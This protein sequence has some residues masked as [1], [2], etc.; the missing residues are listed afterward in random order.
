MCYLPAPSPRGSV[1]PPSQPCC[2]PGHDCVN[3]QM[4]IARHNGQPGP[5]LIVSDGV[6]VQPPSPL[7]PSRPPHTRR[8]GQ[9]ARRQ[10]STNA[11]RFPKSPPPGLQ[12]VRVGGRAGGEGGRGGGGRGDKRRRRGETIPTNQRALQRTL[13]RTLRVVNDR[14]GVRMDR[15]GIEDW[16]WDVFDQTHITRTTT[17]T[18]RTTVLLSL[19]FSLSLILVPTNSH[20]KC[21]ECPTFPLPLYLSLQA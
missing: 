18:T 1:P 13:Q 17:H 6:N 12:T 21:T 3:V 16:E 7:P 14:K 11:P 2:C 8:R 5:P 10:V 4:V 20:Q 15:R 9:G 19:S